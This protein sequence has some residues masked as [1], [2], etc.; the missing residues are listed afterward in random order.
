MSIAISDLIASAET[1]RTNNLPN[2]NTPELV[3][4]NIKN[5]LLLLQDLQS[6]KDGPYYIDVS[7]SDA[8]NLPSSPTDQQK[9]TAYLIGS[10]VYVWNG[11][12]W[13][14]KQFAGPVGEKGDK[15]DSGVTAAAS[16]VAVSD[17][18]AGDGTDATKVYV[19]TANALKNLYLYACKLSST[20]NIDQLYPL[21][22]GYY[23]LATAIAAVE[24]NL[25]AANKKIMFSSAAGVQETYQYTNIDVANWTTVANWE[26]ISITGKYGNLGVITNLNTIARTGNY[27]A[28]GT[29]TGAPDTAYSW[30]IEHINSSA[31][32]VTAYQRAIAYSTDLILYERTKIG[33]TWGNW[34]INSGIETDHLFLAAPSSLTISNSSGAWK[35][36]APEEEISFHDIPIHAFDITLSTTSYSFL[37]LDITANQVVL[38]T[39]EE[40]KNLKN[41]T[42]K[43]ALLG[44]CWM[45]YNIYNFNCNFNINGAPSGIETDH[46][47]LAAPSSLTI[48]NSSGAWK[49][50][51]PEEEISFHDIPIHAFDITLS[52]TSYSFLVLDITANQVVLK[53]FEEWKNLKNLTYKYALLGSCW[54]EYNIYNFNCNFNINGAP[55][56]IETDHLFLAAPSSLTISNSS[57]AWKISAPEEEISFHD[58]P[59]H[60]FD[61]TLSTTSYSFLVLDITANQVVLKTFEEWKNLKNLTYKYALL[62]SC[63]MEYNIYNFN[64]NFN[65]NGAPSGIET[66]HLF[67][68]APSSL[69]ISNSSGAWK[70]SAP[71][72]GI[73]FHD[74]P[75]HAFDITLSTTSYS[76][77]VLD[78]TAN[79][80]VLKTFEEWKN[81]K[82]LTYKYALLGSCW[83]EYNI[84]NFNCNFNING[85]PSGIET[86]FSLKSDTPVVTNTISFKDDIPTPIYK[87]GLFKS[88]DGNRKTTVVLET[89]LSNNEFK[90]Y[91]IN[92][93]TYLKASDIGNSA[94]FVFETQL[95][96]KI[97]KYIT[98]IYK[99]TT[100]GHVSSIKLMTI[101][102]SLTQG[103]LNVSVSP[104]AQMMSRLSSL[105][106]NIIPCGTFDMNDGRDGINNTYIS[107][108]R[109]YWNYQSFAGKASSVYGQTISISTGTG[110][111]SKFENP[112]LKLATTQD[113]T[114]HPDWCFRHT[115][116]ADE[117]SY[118]EDSD[119]TGDFYIFDFAFY[120]TQHSV[121][122]PDIITIALGVNDWQEAGI[123]NIDDVYL[124]MQIIYLQIRSA[125]PNV[126]IMIVPT[127]GIF[128][129][130]Q[131]Q[132]TQEMFPFLERLI[133]YLETQQ[134][135]DNKLYLC[136]IF[137][138]IDRFNAYADDINISNININNNIKQSTM[139]NVHA[140]DKESS[141]IEYMD[142]FEATLLSL[143]D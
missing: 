75:I 18:A 76:F 82:N 100:T 108:G 2:S 38:K 19:G 60:A 124:S 3:G 90:R 46:L 51:A 87:N 77:L 96:T 49:I 88:L 79:Q 10:Y 63:W 140:P 42:Y 27:T 109:G 83:M 99:S 43:Y 105:G 17:Y 4:A 121:T 120:L 84:Y 56:G 67:L 114:D 116:S 31:G 53:T 125:L 58:I 71:E 70:I 112:F 34:I 78:I 45:E 6:A 66:D 25:R 20:L 26:V 41:L 94:K 89:I 98:N 138:H 115:G 40:W 128:P 13:T 135:S 55:S 103:N 62:G 50:S 126:K 130:D 7:I 141:R 61:I 11:T 104:L 142:A 52:T 36:S 8:Q 123:M 73:S 91:E 134:I 74:I 39:F 143:I 72:E 69:T 132:W 48:S 137:Q 15:G 23:T 16:V 28:Y 29:A 32:T 118:S 37:V 80:V 97:Y 9:L 106:I 12:A 81:L 102:D 24:T 33:S 64:C 119:K 35:I 129:A 86:D 101:G 92:N 21:A 93:P 122:T 139:S 133:T 44:S 30:F 5:A 57:G 68:A 136:P 127:N 47:F 1:I 110:L 131:I 54:M 85:A 95:T 65:I 113:K 117:L 59:I 111:T 22:N 14:P 107:E